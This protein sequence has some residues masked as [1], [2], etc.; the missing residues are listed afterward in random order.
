M[1]VHTFALILH[2]YANRSLFHTIPEHGHRGQLYNVDD[3]AP[4]ASA[5][6]L[7][8]MEPVLHPSLQYKRSMKTAWDCKYAVFVICNVRLISFVLFSLF[9]GDV[10]GITGSCCPPWRLRCL[11]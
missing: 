5:C 1:T 6:C 10:D 3:K 2:C 7:P 4:L 8:A 9:V 11:C